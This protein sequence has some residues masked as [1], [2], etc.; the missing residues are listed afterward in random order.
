MLRKKVQQEDETL[1]LVSPT[2]D[3]EAPG[4]EGVGESYPAVKALAKRKPKAPLAVRSGCYCVTCC[5]SCLVGPALF[6]FAIIT[7]T[8]ALLLSKPSPRALP[9]PTPLED[10]F[11]VVV[12]SY[13]RP[14]AL[15]RALEHYRECPG[16]HS[17][18]VIWCESDTPPP[19]D[20]TPGLAPVLY[21]HLPDSLNSRFLPLPSMETEAVF[22]VDDDIGVDC[23][24][25]LVAFQEWQ[26]HDRTLVGF[27]PRSHSLVGPGPPPQYRYDFWW[28][29]W[30]EQE[31]SIVLTKAA[32]LHV[33]YMK[34]YSEKMPVELR[35]YV[36]EKFN[37]EDI[38]M[39]LLV[40]SE[41][42]LPPRYVR[43]RLID[44]GVVGGIST[45]H[46]WWK[47]S[48]AISRDT[49]LTE[50]SEIGWGDTTGMPL[51]KGRADPNVTFWPSTWYEWLSGDMLLVLR[52]FF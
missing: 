5:C 27:Y 31:F 23:P 50:M 2:E 34:I 11:T 8:P 35:E 20:E 46:Q 44:F 49:C 3:L 1:P 51:V 14:R 28:R 16:V 19:T 24:D 45:G 41:S 22:C 33:D 9:V 10:Q 36:D 12:N 52:S 38:L 42:H 6:L 25:L 39:A 40:A 43:G 4:E 48:H 47:S 37:C 30:A 29:V 7:L 15:A 18:R 21:H 26:E 32:F 13:K 17:V